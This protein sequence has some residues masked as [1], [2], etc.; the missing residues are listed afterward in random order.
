M[1]TSEILKDLKTTFKLSNARVNNARANL[2]AQKI[3]PAGKFI[4]HTDDILLMVFGVI[5]A[6]ANFKYQIQYYKD[7]IKNREVILKALY[8]I[9]KLEK[10][11]HITF[12]QWY[13]IVSAPDN[14]S[15]VAGNIEDIYLDQSKTVSGDKL[16]SI[17][18]QFVKN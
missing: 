1:I 14:K 16:L 10:I 12:G 18:K 17:I 5:C 2:S 4:N 15:F 8:D 6:P 13:V 7:L 3:I 9:A 11:N